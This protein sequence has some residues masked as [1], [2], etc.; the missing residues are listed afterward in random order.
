MATLYTTDGKQREVQPK[1]GTDFQLDELYKLL[2]CEMIEFVV[3][4][5]QPGCI[6]IIDEEGKLRAREPNL[7][8]T[9]LASHS[10][11]NDYIVGD[12]LLC[13]AE[14]FK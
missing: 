13:K 5:S 3:P 4:R 7:H 1:N 14:E 2:G 6:L 8:A 10:G 11:L 9:I 12:A